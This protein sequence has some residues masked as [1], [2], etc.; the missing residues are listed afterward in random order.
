MTT[1]PKRST[2]ASTLLTPVEV[3]SRLGLSE[4]TLRNWRV[5]NRRQGPAFVKT[6]GR[7]RYRESA[8]EAWLDAHEAGAA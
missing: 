2:T 8:V 4:G 5:A 3:A 1:S 6:G 7:V